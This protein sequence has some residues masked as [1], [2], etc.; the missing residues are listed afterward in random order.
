MSQSNAAT[1]FEPETQTHAVCVPNRFNGPPTSG[2]GGWTVGL[3]GKHIGPEVEVT[4][5]R[6]IPMDRD[7]HVVSTGH[8]ATLEDAFGLEDINDLPVSYDIGWYEQKAVAILL[9]LFHLGLK[10]IRL[11]PTMPAFLTPNVQ[12]VLVENFNIQPISTPEKDIAACL[13]T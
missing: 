12:N 2:N 6:P 1:V 11:G 13:G 7:I 9:T 5:K 8:E 10:G 3:V 4:L